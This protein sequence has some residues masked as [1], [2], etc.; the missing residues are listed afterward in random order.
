MKLQSKP[1]ENGKMM[2]D[3]TSA[4]IIGSNILRGLF[5]EYETAP[6]FHCGKCNAELVLGFEGVGIEDGFLVGECC[7]TRRVKWLGDESL[8]I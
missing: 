8:T 6:R 3:K 4:A 2:S 7:A 5:A 1:N